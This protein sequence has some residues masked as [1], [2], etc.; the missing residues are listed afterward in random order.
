M[1]TNADGPVLKTQ[2]EHIKIIATSLLLE[3]HHNYNIFAKQ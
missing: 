2:I 3:Q 1:S